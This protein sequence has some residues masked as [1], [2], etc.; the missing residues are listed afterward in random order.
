MSS[1]DLES[2]EQ[3]L[4]LAEA[5]RLLPRQPSPATL[6]RWRTKGILTNGQRIKLDCVRVGGTWC[7]T[8][9]AMAEF[10]RRQTEAAL[11]VGNDESTPERSP[12]TERKLKAAGLL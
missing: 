2:D 9:K 4:T 10:L 5:C 3:L 8:R 1:I 7:T 12:A 6:W 11:S